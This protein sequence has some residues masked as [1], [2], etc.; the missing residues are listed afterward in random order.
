MMLYQRSKTSR[1]NEMKNK[2]NLWISII[3]HYEFWYK[4]ESL[5]RKELEEEKFTHV[6][7]IVTNT[8]IAPTNF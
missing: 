8:L 3:V 6:V 4:G 5:Y 1:V 7:H 2:E